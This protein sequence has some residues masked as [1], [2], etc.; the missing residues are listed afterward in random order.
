MD[1]NNSLFKVIIAGGSLVGLGLALC[2]ERVGIDYVLLEKGEIGPQLGASIGIHPHA[3]KILEQLGVWKDI[4]KVV[5][6]LLYRQHFDEY[7]KCFEDSKVLSEIKQR[8]TRPIIFME[9]CEALRILYSHVQDKSRIHAHTAFKS[10]QETEDG[11]SVTTTRGDVFHGT[12][13][14]GA[15]GIHSHVRAQ[16][17]DEISTTQPELSKEL[18]EGFAAEYKCIFAVSRNSPDSPLMPDGT[19]HNVYYDYYSAVSATGVPGLIFWF[20]FIKMPSVTRMPN[21]P[22]F[23]DQEMEEMIAEYGHNHLGPTYTIKDLWDVHGRVVLIG[24]S[25][26]KATVNPGLG[27]NTAY[28]GIARFTNGL[29]DLLRQSPQPT[30]EQLTEVFRT[31]EEAHRPRAELVVKLSGMITRYEAQDTWYLKTASRW[32]IPW[33]SDVRKADTYVSFSRNGP[34]LAYLPDPDVRE[35]DA[36]EAKL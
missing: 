27:G 12:I 25:V 28:E 29:M 2:F 14:I 6:P 17:A 18:K 7:G 4:E 24:D 35:G 9:R 22:R 32:L 1:T 5:T 8:A 15:D 19:V 16:I 26:H 34:C 21:C 20:L 13:L 3:I 36:V 10:Y 11:V 33:V 30:S 23:G 31:Y